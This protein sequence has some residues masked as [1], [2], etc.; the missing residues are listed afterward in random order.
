[1]Q[2]YL[3]MTGKY[4]ILSRERHFIRLFVGLLFVVGVGFTHINNSCCVL[5]TT[6]AIS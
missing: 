4:S 3:V 1:M 6:K 2:W 5:L